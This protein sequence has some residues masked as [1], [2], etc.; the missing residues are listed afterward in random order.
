MV[1]A[2][3]ERRGGVWTFSLTL[4][5]TDGLFLSFCVL[6][7]R[8]EL[9]TVLVAWA[10]QWNGKEN[11]HPGV[12]LF[13]PSR[14]RSCCSVAGCFPLLEPL[15]EG[16]P[17][18]SSPSAYFHITDLPEGENFSMFQACLSLWRAHYRLLDKG[19]LKHS[20]TVSLYSH[21]SYFL[22]ETP[23]VSSFFRGEE[24]RHFCF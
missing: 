9:R 15:S 10:E 7:A 18:P 5:D 13:L 23:S 2:D 20:F 21:N 16:R 19:L 1:G 22:K 17:W 12:W 6:G 11:P 14:S 4:K 3:L 24:R 8:Y